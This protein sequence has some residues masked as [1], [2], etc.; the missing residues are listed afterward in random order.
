MFAVVVDVSPRHPAPLAQPVVTASRPA[1]ASTVVMAA[2]STQTQ[3]DSADVSPVQ[4]AT[5]V[6]E[7]GSQ[8]AAVDG[9]KSS[10]PLLNK[11]VS[12]V[13]AQKS[14]G[15]EAV[16]Y[17]SGVAEWSCN[18]A[19]R[20][21]GVNTVAGTG[22][23]AP[24]F[25]DRQTARVRPRILTHVIEGFVIQ[26]ANEPFPVYCRTWFSLCLITFYLLLLVFHSSFCECCGCLSLLPFVCVALIEQGLTSH[27]T[28]YR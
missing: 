19:P 23:T 13:T 21:S 9:M 27:Q 3:D 26:E 5:K 10:E 11:S 18:T 14:A 24:S 28:H 2:A 15:C 22:S 12:D 17:S 16:G 4:N 1:S 7:S 20:S 25:I 8:T 6:N